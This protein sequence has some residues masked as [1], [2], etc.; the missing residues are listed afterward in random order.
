MTI[1]AGFTTTKHGIL[2]CAD[3]QYSGAAK[4][5]DS[6]LFGHSIQGDKF[7]F[8]ISGNVVNARMAVEDC[9]D[10]IGAHPEEKRTLAQIKRI[11]RRSIKGVFDEYITPRPIE[12]REQLS[13]E[14]IIGAWLPRGGGHKLFRSMGPGVIFGE[15]YYSVGMGAYLSD[16]LI[17]PVLMGVL[18]MND[19]LILANQAIA[20]C[21]SYDA[22]CGGASQFLCLDANGNISPIYNFDFYHNEVLIREYEASCKKLMLDVFNPQLPQLFFQGR[23]DSFV[24][25]ARAYRET[26]MNYT[27]ILKTIADV[28]ASGQAGQ[29]DSQSTTPDPQSPQPSQ[30]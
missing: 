15:D 1:A 10:A 7:V 9:A 18:S 8:A 12:E 3:S 23:L 19:T 27:G 2:L 24:L 6:K 30:A 28:I 26:W 16:Y 4:T 29:S 5:N 14:L 21:K 17:R 20:A 13:F 22:S 11:L 25:A